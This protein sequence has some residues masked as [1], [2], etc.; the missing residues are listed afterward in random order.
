ML[1]VRYSRI[2]KKSPKNSVR[3]ASVPRTLYT[4]LVVTHSFKKE[5]NY[6]AEGIDS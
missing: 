4:T 3:I 6:E 2:P 1:H 5:V